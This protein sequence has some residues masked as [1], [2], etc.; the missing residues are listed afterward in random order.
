M[1]H[2]H[3]PGTKRFTVHSFSEADELPTNAAGLGVARQA[4]SQRDRQDHVLRRG[5]FFLHVL[6]IGQ[7]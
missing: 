5:T 1:K 2:S 3:V 7:S 4:Q 6:F